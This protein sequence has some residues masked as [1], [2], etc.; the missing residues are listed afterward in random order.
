MSTTFSA[1]A[2][3]LTFLREQGVLKRI[4][5]TP[6]PS[7][8]YLAGVAANAVTN[9]LVQIGLVVIAGRL[10]FGIGWPGLARAG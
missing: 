8:A 10:F 7:G 6:L 2:M 9:A 1:L 3:N 5:G 4:R